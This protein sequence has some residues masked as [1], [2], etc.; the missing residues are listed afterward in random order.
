MKKTWY[1]FLLFAIAFL[2]AASVRLY[3]M[4]QKAGLGLDES[5]SVSYA[6]CNL[7]GTSEK[8]PSGKFINGRQ[9]RALTW[10]IKNSL[11]HDL[12]T[13]WQNSRDGCLPNFYYMLLRTSLSG[14]QEI[15]ADDII[16]RS[17]L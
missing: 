13:L 9:W 14:L 10:D 2:L 3:W 15:S 6:T 8:I 7:I 17:G 16:F 11:F 1:S 12:K 4:S 5:L